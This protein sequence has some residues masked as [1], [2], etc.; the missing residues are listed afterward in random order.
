MDGIIRADLPSSNNE[1]ELYDLVKNCQIHHHSK[2][3]HKCKNQ[4]CR[5][6]FGKCFTDHT[7]VAETLPSEMPLEE[8]TAIMNKRKVLLQNIKHYTDT[9]LNPASKNY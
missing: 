1:P 5:F 3:C 9:E 2:T 6:N 4:K 7:I 8:K